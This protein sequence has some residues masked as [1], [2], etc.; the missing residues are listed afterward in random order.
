[1]DGIPTNVTELVLGATGAIIVGAVLAAVKHSLDEGKRRSIRRIETA[2]MVGA[3]RAEVAGM[4]SDLDHIVTRLESI[5][6]AVHAID[7]RLDEHLRCH[8]LPPGGIKAL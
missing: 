1:M 8:Y 3:V 2:E 5:D 7:D 4:T 6:S